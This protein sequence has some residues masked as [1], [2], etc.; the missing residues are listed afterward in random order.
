ML[1]RSA[2]RQQFFSASP[3]R[4]PGGRK[5]VQRSSNAT[6][7]CTLRSQETHAEHI[8]VLEPCTGLLLHAALAPSSLRRQGHAIRMRQT[9]NYKLRPCD[10]E[11]A[12]MPGS[13]PEV[14]AVEKSSAGLVSCASQD[15]SAFDST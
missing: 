4:P 12:Q 14:N 2:S 9:T 7:K 6:V 8:D 3:L 13:T 5:P 15:F 11:T 10:V 1:C